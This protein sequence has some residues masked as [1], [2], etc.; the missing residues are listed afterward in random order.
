MASPSPRALLWQDRRG[1]LDPQICTLADW[2]EAGEQGAGGRVEVS[3]CITRG[4][5]LLAR[6]RLPDGSAD[7][8]YLSPQE[9]RRVRCLQAAAAARD[10]ATDVR[11]GEVWVRQDT[12]DGRRYLLRA[13]PRQE[14][15]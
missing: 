15:P 13:D 4:D 11:V 9:Q 6:V 5:E 10:L 14:S 12:P 3:M 7:A 2:L 8:I 1:E